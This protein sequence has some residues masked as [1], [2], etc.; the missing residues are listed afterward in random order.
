MSKVKIE[1]NAS[2]T[3][4]LTI[5]APNTN[6]D[7]SLTLP[8]GAGEILTNASTLSSSNLS[9]ALPALDGSAL[10]NLPGGGKLL[11]VVENTSSV[12]STQTMGSSYADITGCTVTITP[13]ASNSKILYYFFAGAWAFT[14]SNTQYLWGKVLRGST[15]IRESDQ[16]LGKRYSS[17]AEVITDSP[18]IAIG[19]DSPATTSA[20]TYKFQAKSTG[21]GGTYIWKFHDGTTRTNNV[22]AIAMEIGA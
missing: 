4:T 21:T 2:G 11:Q 18:A 16:F 19:L 17:G 14:S 10:T 5:S 8:D 12:T 13:T 1:G 7:R 9:G 15:T 22:I 3:G 6:V 20:T